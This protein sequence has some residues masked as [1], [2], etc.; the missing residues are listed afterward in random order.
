MHASPTS[1]DHGRRPTLGT[2]AVSALAL[3][4]V[5]GAGLAQ[6]PAELDALM[7][8]VKSLLAELDGRFDRGD[9]AG[10]LAT[11]RPDHPG[12]HAMLGQRLGQLL[13]AAPHRQRRSELAVPL[14]QVGSRVVARM[15]STVLL[16]ADPKGLER[17]AQNPS[18]SLDD[19]STRFVEDHYLILE[20]AADGSLRPTGCIEVAPENKCL[21]RGLFRC[22]PCNYEVGGVP[23]WLCVPVRGDRAH[24]LEAV[25]FHLLGSD[26]VVDVSVEF[27]AEPRPAATWAAQLAGS[28][29]SLAGAVR[30]HPVEPWVPPAHRS[31]VPKHLDAARLVLD[32][33]QDGI[34]EQGA[35]A[36]LHVAL[37]GGLQHV[38]LLR[39]SK[40]ALQKHAA[41]IDAL[42]GSY[43][44][45]QVDDQAVHAATEALAHHCG[46]LVDGS[47]YKNVL[48][49][50]VLQGPEGWTL[51]QRTGGAAFRAVWTAKNG[52]RLWLTG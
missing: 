43:R 21:T 11:F 28:L 12:Q 20:V 16:A 37:F 36:L 3:L 44:L 5:S 40:T 41:T 25:S 29:Q 1:Q 30:L 34:D 23:G 47:R 35:A 7:P 15:H 9:V 39:G 14:R 6:A 48:Y 18:A 45:L 4:L 22:P 13:G 42:L 46:G 49:D 33:P 32:L 19:G 51:Q 10:Y 38:L 52:A 17:L 24:A 50:L 26:V 8:R 27:A 2:F 31:A